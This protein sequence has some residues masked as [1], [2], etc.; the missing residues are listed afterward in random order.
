MKKVEVVENVPKITEVETTE[1]QTVT[2]QIEVTENIPVKKQVTVTEPITLRKTVEFVEPIITTKVITKETRPTM[3]IDKKITTEVGPASLVAMSR[4]SE[5]SQ[6]GQFRESSQFEQ[7]R[8]NS[9]L[10]E[11]FR[12]M[13][14]TEKERISYSQ[15]SGISTVH[16]QAHYLEK[17]PIY[18]TST[19]EKHLR[20][21]EQTNYPSTLNQ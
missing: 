11:K 4:V 9:Q 3:I 19:T 6:L 12:E 2:R 1:P 17:N 10:D 16:D 13:K 7:Y 20:L 18:T 21:G 15:Q 8:E 5:S 14:I